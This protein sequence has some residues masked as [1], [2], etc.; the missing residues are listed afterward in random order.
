MSPVKAK[1][2]EPAPADDTDIDDVEGEEGDEKIINIKPPII[3][4]ELADKMG[5]KPFKLIAELHEAR[6]ILLVLTN[7]LNPDVA[8]KVCEVYGFSFEKEETRKGRRRS[9]RSK[10]SSKKPEAPKEEEQPE[11]ELKLRALRS[12]PSWGN[13]D[14]SVKLLC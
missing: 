7:Q 10:K 13:V 14:Q 11:E 5:L 1:E 2:P 4:K 8:A 9:Q 6:S 12:S 3:V